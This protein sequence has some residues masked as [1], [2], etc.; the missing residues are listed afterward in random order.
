MRVLGAITTCA[1]CN[2]PISGTSVSYFDCLCSNTSILKH[3]ADLQS[4]TCLRNTFCLPSQDHLFQHSHEMRD[5]IALRKR[6]GIHSRSKVC[7]DC[8]LVHIQWI[9]CG[10]NGVMHG[11]A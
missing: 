7:C 1:S 8:T 4:L 11:T 2:I 10:P 9:A 6:N 5:M 3:S